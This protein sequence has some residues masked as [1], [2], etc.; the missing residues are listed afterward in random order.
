MANIEKLSIALPAEMVADVK[1]A[2][3]DGDYASTSEVIRDALRGW[4]QK[5]VRKPTTVD[6]ND[7]KELRRLIDPALAQLKR[8]E[9]IPAEEVFSRLEKRYRA[10]AKKRKR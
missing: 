10:T 7:I 4:Q 3:H 6:V 5:R 2:V 8:G 1:A 9:G